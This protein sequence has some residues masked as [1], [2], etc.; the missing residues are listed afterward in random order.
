MTV[1]V[2]QFPRGDGEP[3]ATLTSLHHQR[4]L[5]RRRP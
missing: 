3:I 2:A 4:A 1:P 5:I